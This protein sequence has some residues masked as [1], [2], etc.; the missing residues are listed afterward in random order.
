MLFSN[1]NNNKKKHKE[2]LVRISGSGG[3]LKKNP[4]LKW[5]TENYPKVFLK[6]EKLFQI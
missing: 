5:L 1:N 4:T 3:G 6:Y 2:F